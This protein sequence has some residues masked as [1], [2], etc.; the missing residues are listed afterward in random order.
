MKKKISKC[1]EE[2]SPILDLSKFDVSEAGGWAEP[3]LLFGGKLG[4]YLL[5]LCAGYTGFVGVHVIMQTFLVVLTDWRHP[6]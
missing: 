5:I 3:L 6:I 1:K 2:K 4:P